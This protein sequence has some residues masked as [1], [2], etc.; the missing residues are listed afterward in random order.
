MK[1]LDYT[2]TF[3][4][5]HWPIK[6]GPCMFLI[7]NAYG[8]QSKEAVSLLASITQQLQLV[9]LLNPTAF[10]PIYYVGN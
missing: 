4:H 2:L 10:K 6:V 5:K 3:F 9:L 7:S 8:M 1:L